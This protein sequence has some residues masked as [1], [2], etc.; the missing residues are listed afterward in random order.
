MSTISLIQL[1]QY[2]S[3]RNLLLRIQIRRPLNLWAIRVVVAREV[4]SEKIQILGEMKGWAYKGANGLQL[5]TLMVNSKA[6][7]GV[8]DLVWAATMAWTLEET[9]CRKARLLAIQDDERHHL[10]LKRYF[11]KRGF[12]AVRE[13]GSALNDLPLRMIWGGAGTLMIADCRDTLQYSYSR[14]NS[15]PLQ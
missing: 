6:P 13:V 2:A 3:Q 14:W 12:Y 5:D 8:G 10:L 9:P 4:D 7:L 1:E 11:R 15:L